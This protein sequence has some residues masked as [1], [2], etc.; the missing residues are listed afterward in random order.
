MSS[1]AWS[2]LVAKFLMA[3]IGCTIIVIIGVVKVVIWLVAAILP[4]SLQRITGA[5]WPPERSF[6]P[7][8]PDETTRV[9]NTETDW[10]DA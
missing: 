3:V 2:E 10:R 9:R 6:G 4:R 1:N 8:A 7:V 5:P